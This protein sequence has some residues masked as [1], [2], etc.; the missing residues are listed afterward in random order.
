MF[1]KL[2]E[3]LEFLVQVDEKLGFKRFIKYTFIGLF[4]L[5]LIN[6]KTVIRDAIEIVTEISNDIHMK[7]M[8]LRSELLSELKPLLI[9]FRSEVKADRI[10]YFEYHN[11]KENLITIPFKYI[12]LTLQDFRYG[13]PSVDIELYKDIN[14]GVIT[15][16]YEDIKLGNLVFCNGLD[17]YIFNNKYPGVYDFINSRDKSKRYVF[18]S[19]PGINQ[20]IGLI[21][22]EWM[23]ESD[24][25]LPEDEIT[26]IATKN[27]I[28]RINALILSKR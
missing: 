19:I 27:Y 12:E 23:N 11:S 25:L 3:I 2:K 6:Y 21:I 22:L 4:I 5:I 24:T 7:K 26:R 28:P 18:I 13:I 14:V 9:E 16:I 15:D 8:E 17:D 1:E 20:P 10:L